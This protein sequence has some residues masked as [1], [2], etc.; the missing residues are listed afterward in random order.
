VAA[1]A[2]AALF[3]PANDEKSRAAEAPPPSPVSKRDFLR[4]QFAGAPDVDR[5]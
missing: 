4:G 1:A 2:L 5:G 3:D